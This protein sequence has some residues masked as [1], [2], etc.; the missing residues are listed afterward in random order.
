MKN[1]PTVLCG[2]FF[3]SLLQVA[4]VPLKEVHAFTESSV[5]TLENDHQIDYK[6]AD[7]CWDSCYLFNTSGR[8]LA[9]FDCNCGQDEKYDSIVRKEYDVL[10]DYFTALG[11]LAGAGSYFN[12]AP[13]GD[14]IQEGTYG[15][16]TVTANE[17]KVVNALA[18]VATDLFTTRYK[19]KKIKEIL[20]KYHDTV[21]IAMEIMQLHIDNLKSR[22]GLMRTK[23][24]QRG[25][26]LMAGTS[27]DGE[28]W[29]IVYTYK[30]KYKELGRVM[31]TYDKRYQSLE[32]IKQGHQA[33]FENVNDLHSEGLKKKILGFA[34][35]IIY[36]NNH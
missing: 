30:Q 25:D 28:K 31:A 27:A 8:Q 9:D 19:S 3:F 15:N 21:A 24:Q 32:K 4:C 26:L 13:I 14:A 35:D 18:T 2:L 16:L 29:G 23:L 12:F 22:I 34:Y 20:E 7:Y 10:S 17:A 5:Q 33:L 11:K 1:T 36:I 6:Y